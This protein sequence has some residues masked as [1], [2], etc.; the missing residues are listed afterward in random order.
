MLTWWSTISWMYCSVCRSMEA[1]AVAAGLPPALVLGWVDMRATCEK[2]A[3]GLPPALI[4]GWAD[5]RATCE[6]V[7]V[8]LLPSLVPG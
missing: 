6:E 7:A 8:G 5:M 3:V 2:V 4:L 1:L